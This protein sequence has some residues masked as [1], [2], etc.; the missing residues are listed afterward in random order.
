MDRPFAEPP[1]LCVGGLCGTVETASGVDVLSSGDIAGGVVS[2]VQ[3]V[4]LLPVDVDVRPSHGSLAV[5][6]RAS[7]SLECDGQGG[8]DIVESVLQT[9]VDQG[10]AVCR[11]GVLLGR[12]VL[13]APRL[14]VG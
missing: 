14:D 13:P 8:S 3:A 1:V 12:V 10:V 2:Q 9:A 4:W 5:D 11:T 6:A 7:G